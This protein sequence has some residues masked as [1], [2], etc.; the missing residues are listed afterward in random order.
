M[1]VTKPKTPLPWPKPEY[2]NDVGPNDDYFYE[3]WKIEGV[4]E[5]DSEENA[6]FVWNLANSQAK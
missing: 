2:G 4:A 5:F 3:F 6:W 1:N